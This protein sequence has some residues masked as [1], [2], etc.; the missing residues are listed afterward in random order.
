MSQAD[1]VPEEVEKFRSWMIGERKSRHTVKEY[2]FLV[3]HFLQFVNMDVANLGNYEI[4]NYKKFTATVKGYSRNSQYLAIKAIKLFFKYKGITPPT[5]LNP[6]VRSKKLPNY[7]SEA[8]ASALIKAGKSHPK[9]LAIIMTLAYT[10]MRVGELCALDI[11]DVDTDENTIRIRGGKGDKDRIVIMS[12]DCSLSLKEYISSIRNSNASTRAL[13][14]SAK[15]TRYDS[16]TIERIIR[17][18]RDE[19]GISKRVTPHV[20]RHTFATSLLRNGGDIRFIQQILGHA[21][22]ATTQIYTHVDDGML[23]DMYLKYQ[24]KY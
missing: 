12:R 18:T 3:K 11:N 6:P 23:K 19:A 7:L 13:F 2:S 1:R 10:G 4:D 5:N 8:E 20:L 17:Q 24:P 21:S 9:S 16:S 15:G 22:V 14:V